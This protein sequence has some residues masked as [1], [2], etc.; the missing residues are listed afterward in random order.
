MAPDDPHEDL[1][2]IQRD[3]LTQLQTMTQDDHAVVNKFVDDLQKRQDALPAG[4]GVRFDRHGADWVTGHA[5]AR[6]QLVVA[7]GSDDTNR[8][9]D[10]LG[11]LRYTPRDP[12]DPSDERV[13]AE[14]SATTVFEGIDETGR[15]K[16]AKALV[17]D[18]ATL[19]REGITASFNL[20]VPLGQH[21]I[22]AA[23][24]ARPAAPP[25]GRKPPSESPNGTVRIA[26]IDTGL[27]PTKRDDR[28]LDNIPRTAQNEE[29]VDEVPQP[30]GD[31][32]IDVNKGHGDFV[33]GVIEQIEPRC[34]VRAYRF[35]DFDGLGTE[36]SIA[37]ALRLAV[38]DKPDDV[39][40]IINMS[41]GVVPVE[42]IPL[43]ELPAV[44]EWIKTAY[45]DVLLVAAVGNDGGPEMYPASD[46]EVKGV[47]ALN[48]NYTAAKFSAH[49]QYVNC[50]T[51]GVGI[52]STFVTGKMPPFPIEGVDEYE[53]GK[54]AWAVWSG[55]SFACPQICAKVATLCIDEGLY[56]KA[57]FDELIKRNPETIDRFGHV[58]RG[59]LDGVALPDDLLPVADV[60]HH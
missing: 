33:S 35:T 26:V 20:V 22:K 46:D 57:A 15:P 5:V 1:T 55:T 50:S 52:V 17:E 60:H 34:E 23:N 42:E 12:R 25:E 39:R 53:F 49:G 18:I 3:V 6:G 37:E 11:R 30:N 56:P 45:P 10:A 54:D 2:Q 32:Y 24:L 48:P 47:A 38:L 27:V 59:L 31:G 19:K 29:L 21:T 44:I 58:I 14:G 28:W 13:R 4:R 41:F 51:V 40:L 43:L 8:I 36:E 16:D 9:V 7:T